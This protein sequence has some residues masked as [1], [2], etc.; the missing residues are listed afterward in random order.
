[1]AIVKAEQKAELDRLRAG[2]DGQLYTNDDDRT[3]Y[4]FDENGNIYVEAPTYTS[5]GGSGGGGGGF[6][7]HSRWC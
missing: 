7:R 1:M 3:T 4:K 6:C 5:G 2:P